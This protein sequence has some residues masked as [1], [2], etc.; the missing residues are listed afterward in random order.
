MLQ[1]LLTVVPSICWVLYRCYRVLSVPSSVLFQD[2]KLGIPQAPKICIDSITNDTIVIH[3]DIET[4]KDEEILYNIVVNGVEVATVEQTSCKLNKLKGQKYYLIEVVACNVFNQFK[5]VS[6]P[7]CVKTLGKS[8]FS[9]A[10]TIIETDVGLTRSEDQPEQH[11][12]GKSKKNKNK[13]SY[14][15]SASL[16]PPSLNSMIKISIAK[17]HLGKNIPESKVV[18]PLTTELLDEID[19]VE[20]LNVYLEKYQLDLSRLEDEYDSNHESYREQ[21][22]ELVK[23]FEDSAKE[24]E[25]EAGSSVRKDSDVKDY[26]KKREHLIFSK[27]KLLNQ[28]K[29]Q[30]SSKGIHESKLADL[31][32]RHRKLEERKQQIL[33]T[34]NNEHE[35]FSY[36]MNK[37]KDSINNIKQT[38]EK[39]EENT[40]KLT[41]ERKELLNLHNTLEPLVEDFSNEISFSKDGFLLPRAEEKLNQIYDIMPEWSDEIKAEIS[42]SMQLDNSWKTAYKQAIEQYVTTFNELEILRSKV[43]AEYSP[44]TLNDY[45]ASM[46]F[47]GLGNVLFKKST[48]RN[49]SPQTNLSENSQNP[50]SKL[51]KRQ[52]TTSNT[53]SD[54]SLLGGTS[55]GS[56]GDL[57]LPY[58]MFTTSNQGLN[59]SSSYNDSVHNF[60][61]TA[62]GAQLPSHLL[63]GSAMANST[64]AFDDSGN[65]S[66]GI[67]NAEFITSSRTGPEQYR[68]S[69]YGIDGVQANVSSED[70]FAELGSNFGS[71]GL[72]SSSVGVVPTVRGSA[73]QGGRLNDRDFNDLQFGIPSITE[74]SKLEPAFMFSQ[75]SIHSQQLPP[76]LNMPMFYEQQDR[77]QIPDPYQLGGKASFDDQPGKSASF[78]GSGLQNKYQEQLTRDTS[79]IE[80][81][82]ENEEQRY[83]G[84]MKQ[85]AKSLSD[86]HSQNMLES[87]NKN[88]VQID[89]NTQTPNLLVDSQNID[90]IEYPSNIP[91]S[92]GLFLSQ[93][94]GMSN[95]NQ[96]L[97][98]ELSSREM[99]S[100]MGESTPD[101]FY[102]YNRR[103]PGSNVWSSSASAGRSLPIGYRSNGTPRNSTL[104][105]GSQ[106]MNVTQANSNSAFIDSSSAV[107][108]SEANSTLSR[109]AARFGIPNDSPLN[110]LSK[111][112]LTQVGGIYGGLSTNTTNMASMTH[113]TGLMVPSAPA[114]N[115]MGPSSFKGT[116]SPV[117][118]PS[119]SA[120]GSQ[121]QQ[122]L[123]MEP[124]ESKRIGYSNPAAASSPP[125]IQQQPLVNPGPVSLSPAASSYDLAD[126][127][128]ALSSQGLKPFLNPQNVS[129]Q[130]S[131]RPFGGLWSD[132]STYRR[133]LSG[134]STLPGSISSLWHSP[135]PPVGSHE[136]LFPE[137]PSKK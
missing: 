115:T 108:S 10:S 36:K 104:S 92:S 93:K 35:R 25:A 88:P 72:S 118:A 20:K 1:L 51:D 55:N 45:E 71:T 95:G 5:S 76:S 37:I 11:Q 65:S 6:E 135:N 19:S 53:V 116:S 111:D 66:S 110:E 125:S 107:H 59:H 8:R 62:D 79:E 121:R 105:P 34:G 7:V 123:L 133:T 2:L 94:L 80:R 70:S 98:P 75:P 134:S 31:L 4:H 122:D 13:S 33:K 46:E 3:W 126:P 99:S 58:N 69:L 24:L 90:F 78:L 48:K 117:I 23:E 43:N 128:K 132:E 15:T 54:L 86:N 27:S 28:L 103:N 82:H 61:R 52:T 87:P 129:S 64:S 9:E 136:H 18:T 73:S 40:K 29:A 130:P 60:S 97:S 100:L 56:K 17:R 91:S 42:K 120:Q 21:M 137:E 22:A 119:I 63:S 32:H 81:N 85:S 124:F 102:L 16:E 84:H 67:P 38:I 39:S 47:G 109:P 106:L 44:L 57:A 101:N 127:S 112:R 83:L 12:K 41:T 96:T 26:E 68:G 131:L 49:I 77:Q 113:D 114:S 89:N 30:E 14:L 50:I 74:P